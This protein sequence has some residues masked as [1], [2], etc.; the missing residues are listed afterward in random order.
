MNNFNDNIDKPILR[1]NECRHYGQESYLKYSLLHSVG[2][3]Q[4]FYLFRA[5]TNFTT[6]L[7]SAVTL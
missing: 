2:Y 7:M 5:F 6:E 1:T 4:R 3:L